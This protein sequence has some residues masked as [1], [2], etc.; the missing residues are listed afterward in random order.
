MLKEKKYDVFW[1]ISRQNNAWVNRANKY[2]KKCEIS[3][4]ELTRIAID[5]FIDNISV[6]DLKKTLQE[7]DHYNCVI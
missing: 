4:G 1:P 7:Y 6:Q 5:Y 2:R 3:R